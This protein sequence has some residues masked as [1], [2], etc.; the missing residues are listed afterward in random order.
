M[1]ERKMSL[2]TIARLLNESECMNEEFHPNR[3]YVHDEEPFRF[4]VVRRAE[5]DWPV[6]C[7]MVDRLAKWV[8]NS[9]VRKALVVFVQDDVGD[10]DIVNAFAIA[11]VAHQFQGVEPVTTGKYGPYNWFDANGLIQKPKQR[12]FKA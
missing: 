3:L 11:E 9:I 5:F 12:R 8:G 7:L 10:D 4:L 6:N 2:E 1:L